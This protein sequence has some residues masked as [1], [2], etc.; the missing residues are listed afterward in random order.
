MNIALAGPTI[1]SPSK[2]IQETK[3]QKTLESYV[4]IIEGKTAQDFVML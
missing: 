3:S 4:M 2:Q 1:I